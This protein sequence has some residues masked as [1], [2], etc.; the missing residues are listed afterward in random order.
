MM[1]TEHVILSAIEPEDVPAIVRWR[2]M[3]EVFQGFIEYEP[4]STT[5]QLA[6]LASLTPTGT[7]RLWMINAIDDSGTTYEK[8]VRPAENAV[9]V[10]TVGIMDIDWRNRRC[11]F[12]PIF[13]GELEYRGR[14]IALAAE[15]LVLDYCFNHMGMHK[16][17][18]H[19]P[20]S[21]AAVN[22][23]HEAA[24]FRHDILL[25]DHIL[26]DGKFEGLHLLSCLAD[27]FQK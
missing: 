16:V 15:K 3:P 7:R 5:Q 18:A 9:P 4:L 17:I 25:R 24:G 12:G 11:E 6:F 26:R 21:N 22:R 2:N 13:I 14:G 20:K 1:R 27:E 19:V 10:G 23:L 8:T